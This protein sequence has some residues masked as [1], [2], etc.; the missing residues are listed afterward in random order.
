[1]RSSFT[2]LSAIFFVT[3]NNVANTANFKNF[4]QTTEYSP[5]GRKTIN[6][7]VPR[8]RQSSQN[9]CGAAVTLA[10]FQSLNLNDLR[11]T[12]DS[13]YAD[14]NQ[15]SSQP[16]IIFN[17][18]YV[19]YL[20]NILRNYYDVTQYNY[21]SSLLLPGYGQTEQEQD[22]F[23]LAV[24]ASLGSGA[25]VALSHSNTTYPAHAI[26]INEIS[27]D[28]NNP[29]NTTYRYMDPADGNFHQITSRNLSS[30]FPRGG[31][32]VYSSNSIFDFKSKKIIEKVKDSSLKGIVKTSEE[33]KELH[34]RTNI[35]TSIGVFCMKMLRRFKTVTVQNF[36]YNVG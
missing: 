32:I 31:H 24:A 13:I 25:P 4:K 7:Q 19:F 8:I 36:Y 28:P 15:F 1:M 17:Q 11:V 29:L 14:L 20:N 30:L 3:F 16:G 6:L 34:V 26:L 27:I 2:F 21:Q 23:Q 9:Y 5:A 33:P 10:I 22:F 35:A 12:Q 18:E